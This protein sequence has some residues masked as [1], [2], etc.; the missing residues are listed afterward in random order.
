MQVS[1]LQHFKEKINVN[2]GFTC[3][4]QMMTISVENHCRLWWDYLIWTAYRELD[5]VN[6]SRFVEKYSGVAFEVLSVS[7]LL[8]A[9]LLSLNIHTIRSM[10][11][12]REK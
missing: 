10:Q 5:S 6:D 4:I 12:K 7:F 11:V 9:C 3:N 2:L 1:V 8:L